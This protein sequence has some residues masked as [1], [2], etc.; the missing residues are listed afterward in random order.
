MSAVEGS[1]LVVYQGRGPGAGPRRRV[2][3]GGGVPENRDA[4]AGEG[5]RDGA[6]HG[7]G[8]PVA[9]L[10][11]A[12][13]LLGIFYRNLGRAGGQVSGGQGQV[14]AFPVVL[15]DEHG[16]VGAGAE[17]PMPQAGE[18]G[19]GHGGGA[20]VPVHGHRGEGCAGS[21]RGQGRQP[22]ALTRGRPRAPGAQGKGG[23]AQTARHPCA[24]G[25]PRSPAGAG[26]AV[27]ARVGGIGH[28]VQDPAGQGARQGGSPEPA[29][30]TLIRMRSFRQEGRVPARLIR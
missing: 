30:N 8:Q 16:L 22:V 23:A 2:V 5:E 12:E 17:D 21:E 1:A 26:G 10:P 3:P 4:L 25:S 15:A 28:H 18:G 20:A 24:A 11:G 29:R 7:G 14:I 6:V 19:G 9:G 27:P 13:D